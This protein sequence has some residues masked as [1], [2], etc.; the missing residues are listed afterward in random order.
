ML[1]GAELFSINPGRSAARVRL[2]C[3]PHAGGSAALFRSWQNELPDH[4]EV[5]ALDRSDG[6][7]G[8]RR[9]DGDR[10]LRTFA[11]TLATSMQPLLDRPYALFGHSMGALVAFELARHLS[12]VGAPVPLAVFASGCRAPSLLPAPTRTHELPDAELLALLLRLG[13][14]PAALLTDHEFQG[15]IL[16]AVRNDYALLASYIYEPTGPLRCPIAVLRGTSDPETT[17]E[18]IAGWSTE[19]TSERPIV[20]SFDGGHFF[21]TEARTAVLRAVTDALTACATYR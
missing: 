2:F 9:I 17:D 11:V 18:R 6:A 3:F 19:T 15:P 13:G 14:T 5:C 8:V 4:I 21:P 20:H 12:R 10:D 16:A 7:L 1:S